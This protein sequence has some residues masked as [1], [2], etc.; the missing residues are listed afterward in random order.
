MMLRR[1]QLRASRPSR[2]FRPVAIVVLCGLLESAA[3]QSVVLRT[4]ETHP[5]DYPTTVALRHMSEQLIAWSGGDMALKIFS[6]GQ[7][8]EEKDVLELTVLGSID[9]ARVS[10][11]PLNAIAEETIAFS[12]PF[13]FRSTEHLRAVLDGQ[14]GSEVLEALEPHGLIG[15]AYYDSGARSIYNAEKPIRTPQDIAGLKIRVQNS[16]VAVAMIEAMGGN[17]TPMGFGQVYEALMLGAIDGSENNWPSYESAGHFEVAK[18]YT[19]TRH[20]MVPEVLV[21]SKVRWGRLTTAERVL[22]RRAATDSVDVMRREWDERVLRSKRRL[23][24]DGVE[25]IDRIDSEAFGRSVDP[26]YERFINNDRLR[27]LVERIRAAGDS[28]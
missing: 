9:V 3:G 13:V 21:V 26:V 27:D 4:A 19:L 14:I 15:L 1:G 7:L 2:P 28:N 23:I 22:L 17:P 6:G 10:L 8:G 11:A 5:S 24:A 12:M 20:T 18:Y 25:V 16:D